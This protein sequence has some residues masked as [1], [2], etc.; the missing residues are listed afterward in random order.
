[1]S[2]THR[3]HVKYPSRGTLA[4]I[5][6]PN[7]RNAFAVYLLW[8]RQRYYRMHDAMHHEASSSAACTR[9]SDDAVDVHVGGDAPNSLP[10]LQFDAA[11]LNTDLLGIGSGLDGSVDA[12][13]LMYPREI[14]FI[15]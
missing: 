9:S 6:I 2:H 8:A 12:S 13:E 3:Y 10:S 11:R 15:G 14:D 7:H 1:M 4:P 5:G